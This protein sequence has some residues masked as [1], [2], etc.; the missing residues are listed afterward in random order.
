M[1]QLQLPDR[2][3]VQVCTLQLLTP[4][5]G[6]PGCQHLTLSLGTEE[7]SCA[8]FCDA[9]PSWRGGMTSRWSHLKC[10]IPYTAGTALGSFYCF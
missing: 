6:L 10:S 3:D 9:V 7:T 4:T 2:F 1:H 5:C 8:C